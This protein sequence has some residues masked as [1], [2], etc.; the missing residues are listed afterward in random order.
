ML[1]NAETND[2]GGAI[3]ELS[4]AESIGSIGHFSGVIF[5]FAMTP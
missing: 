3:A 4:F 2:D 5:R 1:P